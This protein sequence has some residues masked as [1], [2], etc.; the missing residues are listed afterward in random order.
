[1]LSI[2]KKLVQTYF[3]VAVAV[4]VTSC[5]GSN[6][7]ENQLPFSELINTTADNNFDVEAPTKPLNL[8]SSDITA[9]QVVLSWSLSSDNIAVTGYRVTRDSNI[10]AEITTTSYTDLSLTADTQYQYSIVAF[11]AENNTS[12]S[13]QLIVTTD[14]ELVTT[15]DPIAMKSITLTW[16]S[17]VKNIDNSCIANI[18]SY[19][20]NYGTSS[21]NYSTTEDVL[22]SSG[23]ISCTQ[24]SYDADCNSDVLTC[25]YT[26][27]E[28]PSDTWYFAIQVVDDSG[29]VS[30]LSNEALQIIN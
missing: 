20:V 6:T 24:H 13:A 28:L 9:A 2:I 11:D 26:T 16:E 8:D 4:S 30:N 17:P 7:G 22:L 18:D 14:T 21:N 23:E 10:I 29:Y 27:A 3:A 19:K 25:T 1:M 12:E 5:T 15:T